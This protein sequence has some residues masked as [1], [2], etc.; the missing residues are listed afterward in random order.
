MGSTS[1]PGL[2]AKPIIDMAAV[3]TDIDDARRAVGPMR[4]VGWLHDPHPMTT[5]TVN[6]RSARRLSSGARI[7]STWSRSRPGP[8]DDWLAFRDYL[9]THSDVAAAVRRPQARAGGRARSGSEPTRGVRERQDRLRRTNR[10]ARAASPVSADARDRRARPVAA[11]ANLPPL[12]RSRRGRAAGPTLVP[13][14]HATVRAVQRDPVATAASLGRFRT[15]AA[16]RHRSAG[17]GRVA[18]GPPVH[19]VAAS[20]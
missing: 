1:V 17:P 2:P 12:S 3:V 11:A 6:S 5:S 4:E 10:S 15:L 8:G 18:A 16:L 9:R 20:R 14:A 13:R 7:T 19:R